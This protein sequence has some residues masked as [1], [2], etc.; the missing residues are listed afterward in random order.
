MKRKSHVTVYKA[1]TFKLS[2]RQKK[3][4][5]NYCKARHTTPVKLI[6]ESIRK[7]TEP[8]AETKPEEIPTPNQLDLFED[9]S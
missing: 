3:S 1:I 8:Y 4:L 2:S 6:K 5:L 7:Y 9:P